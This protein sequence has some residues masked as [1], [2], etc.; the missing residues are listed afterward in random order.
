[1]SSTPEV[2]WC[3]LES[4]LLS[5]IIPAYDEEIRLPITLSHVIDFVRGQ[6]FKTEIL[7]VENGSHDRTFQIASEFAKLYPEIIAIHEGQRGKGLAVKRGMLQA[8]GA[9]LFMCDADLSMP[10]E[11]I[12]KFIPPVLDDFDI[13]IAS[14]EAPGSK[15]FQE[16]FYR[17]FGGR[18]INLMIRLLALP[19]LQ[20]TQCGFKCFCREVARDL[21]EKMTLTGWSFDIEILFVARLRGYKIVEVPIPW[22]F[23]PLSKLSLLKDTLRMAMDI[24]AVRRNADAGLYELHNVK[25]DPADQISA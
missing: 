4:P 25:P 20:D 21:F 2:D 13:A 10:V 17:H 14:R 5:I 18:L 1:L 6:P 22:Y 16:P 24:L 9:F 3:K 8:N 12:L 7:V 11:E 23:N 15:R 19:G